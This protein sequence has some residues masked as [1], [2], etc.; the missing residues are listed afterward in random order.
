MNYHIDS[1]HHLVPRP[2]G[3]SL[4][5]NAP[6]AEQDGP[7]LAETPPSETTQCEGQAPA[8]E[9]L[10]Q[11]LTARLAELETEL[12]AFVTPRSRARAEGGLRRPDR[13]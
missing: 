7:A 13:R 8:L 12:A 9:Q 6:A 5:Q 11:W 3:D 10:E 2:A 1:A 4:P